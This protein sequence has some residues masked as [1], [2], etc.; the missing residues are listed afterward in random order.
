MRM[1]PCLNH[2]A[3]ALKGFYDGQDYDQAIAVLHAD[4]HRRWR[5]PDLVGNSSWMTR[6]IREPI[7][8]PDC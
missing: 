2:V 3:G 1:P 5:L 6:A 7:L 8:V 4:R